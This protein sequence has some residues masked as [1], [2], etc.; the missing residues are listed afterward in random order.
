MSINDLNKIK[1][2]IPYVSPVQPVELKLDHKIRFHCY[3]GI[4]CFN[5]CCRNIDITLTPHD[6]IRLKRRMNMTSSQWVGR[7]TI[8]FPMDSHG[9]PGLKL[10]TKP[11]INEC[12]FLEKKGCSVYQDRPV[13]CR[14]YALGNMGVKKQGKQS[15]DDIFFIVKEE[16]C[17]G[18]DEPR[19]LT[20]KEYLEEQEVAEYD[21]ANY[22]W[23][24]IVLKKRS[25]GPTVG[26]PTPRSLQLFDMC[27]YDIDNFRI[28]FE[29]DGFQDVFDI[30]QSERQSLLDNEDKL[31]LFACRFLKQVLYGEM[32]IK[33]KASASDKRRAKRAKRQKADE[34]IS[35]P[36]ISRQSDPKSGT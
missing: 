12:I 28:F 26:K 34:N 5:A 27:S 22:Q 19:S 14:Y 17:K 31:F 24:D 9:M 8:P 4:S 18:H 36:E 32:S 25:A 29:S 6:I 35:M 2:E 16:H 20:V 30:A 23:R 3:K 11:G 13:S 1:D 15:V 7:Y 33:V 21:Q 10:A